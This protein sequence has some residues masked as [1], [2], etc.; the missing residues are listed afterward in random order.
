MKSDVYERSNGSDRSLADRLRATLLAARG[1]AQIRERLQ[2]IVSDPERLDPI[3]QELGPRH[4]L[5]RD[6]LAITRYGASE[7]EEA[8]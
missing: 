8:A 1:N 3:V 6:L 5:V 7:T 2:T 4:A